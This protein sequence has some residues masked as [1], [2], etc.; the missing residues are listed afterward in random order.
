MRSTL[1]VAVGT[2]DSVLA[3]VDR[4]E[5]ATFPDGKMGFDAT[6]GGTRYKGGGGGGVRGATTGMVDFIR[7]DLWW[8]WFR[9]RSATDTR[10][11]VD[12]TRERSGDLF[13]VSSPV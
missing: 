11:C 7:P 12:K 2:L 6:I 4:V 3:I 10:R 9:G 1:T 13:R 5:L 8:L